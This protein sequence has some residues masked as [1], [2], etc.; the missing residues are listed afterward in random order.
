MHDLGNILKLGASARTKI[1]LSLEVLAANP[2]IS[3]LPLWY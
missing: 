1:E 3:W 2:P